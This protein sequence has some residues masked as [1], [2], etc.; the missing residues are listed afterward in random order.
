MR[1]SFRSLYLGGTVMRWLYV[2][3]TSP[4]SGAFIHVYVFIYAYTLYSDF[5]IAP[6][7]ESCMSPGFHPAKTTGKIITNIRRCTSRCGSVFD[8]DAS[9]K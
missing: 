6:L 7:P 8:R 2:V 5:V 1:D 3:C 4:P 9:Q